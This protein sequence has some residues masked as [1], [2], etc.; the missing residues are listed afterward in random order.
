MNVFFVI[1]GKVVTPALDD[2]NIL[3]GVTRRSCIE[4]LKSKGYEVEERKVSV[5]ELV[6][7][8][9]AGKLNESFGTGTAAVISPVGEYIDGDYH[10]VINNGEIGEIS[11]M[12]YDT[13]TGIQWGKSEDTMGWTV[14]VK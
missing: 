12:L 5:D 2:G 10:M 11:Q 13:M 4:I 7:A 9:K 3:P 8:H 1:D 14:V 6:E